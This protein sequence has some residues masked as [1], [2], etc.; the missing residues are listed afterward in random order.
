MTNHLGGLMNQILKL[1]IMAAFLTT[2]STQGFAQISSPIKSIDSSGNIVGGGGGPS[3]NIGSGQ[4]NTNNF[5]ALRAVLDWRRERIRCDLERRTLL[6][7]LKIAEIKVDSQCRRIKRASST[8]RFIND[9]YRHE[10]ISNETGKDRS[11]FFPFSYREDKLFLSENNRLSFIRLAGACDPRIKSR[12][13]RAIASFDRKL[14]A[15]EREQERIARRQQR[16][17]RSPASFG[18]TRVVSGG[19]PSNPAGSGSTAFVQ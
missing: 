6:N 13:E 12:I 17:R 16:Q 14:A 18:P 4:V 7:T 10:R 9:Y 8:C 15:I 11:R 1:S 19:G 5:E 2:F 3:S